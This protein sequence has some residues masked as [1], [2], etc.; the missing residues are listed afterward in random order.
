MRKIILSAVLALTG[1]ALQNAAAYEFTTRF[2][3]QHYAV[4]EVILGPNDNYSSLLKNIILRD[5]QNH[6]PTGDKF[7]TTT[8]IFP[9]GSKGM[10][11]TIREPTQAVLTTYNYS[12]DPEAAGHTFM[13]NVKYATDV[14]IYMSQRQ[15][16]TIVDNRVINDLFHEL[17]EVPLILQDFTVDLNTVDHEGVRHL[18]MQQG[19]YI[20]DVA[21]IDSMYYT[22]EQMAAIKPKCKVTVLAVT[23]RALTAD[24][25]YYLAMHGALNRHKCDR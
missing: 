16:N 23:D 21:I 15:L 20:I 18:T 5:V 25:P 19:G 2:K 3:T 24:M 6:F 14:G 11:G 12:T 8:A 13:D 1:L 4:N 17:A 10:A 22:P 9:Y 7:Q